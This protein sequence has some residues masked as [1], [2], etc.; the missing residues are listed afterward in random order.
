V[1]RLR[2]DVG[3]AIV[4]FCWL[5][6]LLLVPLTYVVLTVFEVQKAA[7]AASSATREA[8]RAFVS[9]ASAEAAYADAL[10]AARIAAADHG[11]DLG[12]DEVVIAC[13]PDPGCPP[14][15]DQRIEVRVGLSVPLP[16]VPR[17]LHGAVPAWVAVSG[18]HVET[19]DRYGAVAR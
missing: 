13:S 2:D 15:A 5:A 11:L 8:G 17:L 1:T 7:Y 10:V 9:S 19:V 16:L 12:P 6:V 4:E 18:R 14:T 3:G